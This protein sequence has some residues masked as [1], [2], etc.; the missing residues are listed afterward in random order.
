MFTFPV[1]ASQ[2]R[3]TQKA[4][5]GSA[6]DGHYLALKDDQG[7][8]MLNGNMM[9]QTSSKDLSYGGRVIQYSGVGE[10]VESIKTD[11]PLTRE[12]RLELFSQKVHPKFYNPRLKIQFYMPRP[13]KSKKGGKVRKK[14]IKYTFFLN[15]VIKKLK[16]ISKNLILIRTFF[17]RRT[18]K[19]RRLQF[20][21][22]TSALLQDQTHLLRDLQLSILLP[23]G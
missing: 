5:G 15:D 22:T 2:I 17:N 13:K 23:D 9:L 7:R 14:F 12:L 16:K 1:G 10:K 3:I 11:M 4:S 19:A 6:Y 18:K 21:V 20:T 8:F